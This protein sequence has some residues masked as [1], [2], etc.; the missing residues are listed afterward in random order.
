MRNHSQSEGAQ[1]A[2]LIYAFMTESGICTTCHS[3][4]AEPDRRK[5]LICQEKRLEYIRKTKQAKPGKTRE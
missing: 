2:R 3:R 1:I 5:C 4:W